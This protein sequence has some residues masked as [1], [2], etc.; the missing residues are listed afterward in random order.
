[1]KIWYQ[2]SMALGDPH[3]EPYEEFLKK[4]VQDCVKPGTTVTVNGVKA[5]HPG[6]SHSFYIESLNAG[7]AIDNAI[8]AEREGYDAFAFGC[9][10]DPAHQYI[11]ECVSIP[12]AFALETSIH[13]ACLL[14]DKFTFLSHHPWLLQRAEG[15][16]KEYGLWERYLPSNYIRG[17]SGSS[18]CEAPTPDQDVPEIDPVPI[19]SFKDPGP[20][21]ESVTEQ[22]Q[23]AINKGA[24]M[25]IQ[26]C[27][28][29]TAAMIHHNI[30]EINGVP[31]LDSSGAVV[32][33]A[34]FL[35]EMKE[36]GIDRSKQGLRAPVSKEEILEARELWGLK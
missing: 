20:L 22:A 4:H 21:V 27:L 2:S 9:M 33:T 1:M 3:F 32:K 26:S 35:V 36:I 25:L 14:A 12:V 6:M 15:L 19:E 17:C 7:G 28:I 16:I 31:I 18:G 34:E 24:S 29:C 11:R 10:T 5:H 23:D 13:L 30:R 8:Q